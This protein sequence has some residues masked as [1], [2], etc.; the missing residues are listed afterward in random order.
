MVRP[1]EP[2]G[3]GPR[4]ALGIAF[5]VLVNAACKVRWAEL[6]GGA[7]ARVFAKVGLFSY[8][9]YLTHEV[10]IVAVKHLGLRAGLGVYPVMVLRMAIPIAVAYVFYL[11]VERRFIH[12][13]RS[14]ARAAATPEGDKGEVFSRT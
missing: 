7:I 13:S 10:V 2:V 5:F 14:A 8:S 4:V 9:L 6:T 3:R 1:L 11:V 12:A